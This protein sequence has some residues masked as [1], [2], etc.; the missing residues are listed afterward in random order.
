MQMI[1]RLVAVATLSIMVIGGVSAAEANPFSTLSGSWR[2]SGQVSPYGGKGE[3]VNCRVGYSVSGAQITQSILCA[4]TDYKVNAKGK[5]TYA[6]GKV[7]GTWT[8]ATYKVGG[9]VHGT[10][11][12][13]AMFLRITGDA[14]SGR[15]AIKGGGGSSHTVHI[16]QFDP[17]S[18]KYTT[19]ANMSLSR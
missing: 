6:K 18:G 7:S 3:R 5:L 17:G 10:A 16:T 4:G 19:L 2:G 13:G 14:F 15:M 8:E 12:P 11:K 9:K 1:S